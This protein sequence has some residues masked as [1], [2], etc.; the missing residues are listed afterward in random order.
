MRNILFIAYYFPPLGGAGVQRSLKF[1]KYLPTCDWQPVVLTVRE[2]GGILQDD[3]LASDVPPQTKIYRTAIPLLPGYLPWRFRNWISRW[4]LVVDEQIGWMPFAVRAGQNIINS[5]NIR[6]IYSTSGPYTSHLIGLS[7][8]RK[9]GLPWIADF[10]DPWIG[11]FTIDYPT[12]L[13]KELVSICERNIIQAADIITVVSSPMRQAL[14]ERYSGHIA[15]KIRV[16]PNGYDPDDFVNIIPVE[17]NRD[18][19]TIVY[20]GS[21][22]RRG[23]TPENFLRGLQ[24]AI[25]QRFIARDQI[26][27]YFIGNFGRIIQKYLEDTGLQDVVNTIGYLPHKKSISYLLIADVLLLIIGSGQGSEAIYTGKIFEYL[28][29][30]KPILALADSGAAAQLVEL[31]RAGVAVPA[32]DIPAIA[33][34]IIRLFDSWKK[35]DL[36]FHRDQ[37]II[38]Q[39]DRRK[40]TRQLATILNDLIDAGSGVS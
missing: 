1:V 30:G 2:M 8:K 27:V 26:R 11:S 5:E 32:D 34:Q 14:L 6:V 36:H 13:H 16:L 38:N 25:E 9:T 31:T 17:K 39:F 33:D 4:L 40:L 18:K 23:R 35:N 28:A 29:A 7:L 19:F 20:T 24:S 22:Y 12:R 10:R 3:S 37:Q 21:L 15:N